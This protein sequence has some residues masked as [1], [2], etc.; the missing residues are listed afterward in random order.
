[1][2]FNLHS[3]FK[4]VSVLISKMLK[5]L[6]IKDFDF[7]QGW[8]KGLVKVKKLNKFEKFMTYFWLL[9]PFIYL[10]ERDPA[11][12]WLSIIS[13]IFIFRCFK[14]NDWFWLKQTW[15]RFAFLF[16]ICSILSSLLSNFPLYSLSQSIVWIR[17]PLYALAA[18]TW[19]A[20]DRDIRIM[21]LV[22]ILIGM[23]TMCLILIAETIIDPKLRLSW[24]YGDL[25]PGGY[26]VKVSLP[27]FCILMA[28][29]TKNFGKTNII[30]GTIGLFTIGISVL[31]GERGHVLIR[32]V[33][34]I[35]SSIVWKPNLKIILFLILTNLLLVISIL[36][37]RPDLEDRFIK[38][39]IKSIP[40]LNM[41]VNKGE[42]HY[43]YW[44]SWRAGIQ[45]SVK[46][47]FVGAGPSV[48]RLTCKN[49]PEHEP[50]WLPGLNYC[51]NHPHNFYIQMFAETG[52]FGFLSGTAMLL[53]IVY[54]CFRERK[55]FPNCPMV[56]TA[57]ITPLAIF[58]P[59]QNF[60]SLYGQW[61][62]LFIWFAV[63]FALSQVQA[64]NRQSSKFN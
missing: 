9:G 38:G 14:R 62:N 28:I 49:L 59:I 53:A 63:G 47:P 23:I 36:Q 37:I 29:S 11:D 18:Q 8:Q 54:A 52:I 20:R 6:S 35:V 34:G 19:L 26:L 2:F 27:L 13:V 25:V 46:T 1:M 41:K 24:P 58:F 60:G 33:S 64:W 16:W 17:F 7:A 61:G 43:A 4:Y 50:I 51:G 56:T 48:M 45:Q 30:S 55:F 15:V 57:F 5:Y 12:L 21:M 31:T 3:I 44:G 40:F 42:G 10:I 22:S 32:V 39:T